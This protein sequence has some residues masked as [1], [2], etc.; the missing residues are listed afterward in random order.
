M[1]TPAVVRATAGMPLPVLLDKMARHGW[2]GLERRHANVLRALASLLPHRSAEGK[3]TA[4]QVADAGSYSSRWTRE[5]L[6]ELED[7]GLV[8]WHRGGVRNG[9]PMPS[10]FRVVKARLVALLFDGAQDY[11]DAMARRAAATRARIAGVGTSFPRRSAHRRRSVH[12][13]VTTNPTL[14][15]EVTD[16]DPV[17]SPV[18]FGTGA[19]P[20]TIKSELA[21]LRARFLRPG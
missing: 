3:A 2:P 10:T 12:A 9:R 20:A 11:V 21:A 14:K 1:A 6:A 17:A 7:L 15:R 19:P 8:E 18:P 16:G 4:C 13:E 5:A